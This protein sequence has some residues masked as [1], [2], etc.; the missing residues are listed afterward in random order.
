MWL[1]LIVPI[2]NS[3]R[4]LHY[5]CCLTTIRFCS[6]GHPK[7]LFSY[8]LI[9]FTMYNVS[10]RSIKIWFANINYNF[11]SRFI[12]RLLFSIF[13]IRKNILKDTNIYLYP[14][15]ETVAFTLL[16]ITTLFSDFFSYS[17]FWL[18]FQK[19]S[20]NPLLIAVFFFFTSLYFL[21]WK[22]SLDPWDINLSSLIKHDKMKRIFVRSFQRSIWKDKMTCQVIYLLPLIANSQWFML[23][24]L[25]LIFIKN[26]CEESL[27]LF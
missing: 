4:I 8:M 6:K 15:Y 26:N 18:R 21:K 24:F 27:F 19:K 3:V 23:H 2:C 11:T 1:I 13:L 14:L 22:T 16:I 9:S 17:A 10:V 25:R 20:K 5:L 7:F 12:W